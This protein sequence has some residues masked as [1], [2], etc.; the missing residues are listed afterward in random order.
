MKK[1]RILKRLHLF[2]DRLVF[3]FVFLLALIPVM[4]VAARK[5]F[6]T[7][8]PNST[9]YIHHLVLIVTF[10]GGM[11]TTREKKHLS[12]SLSFNL[13]K[14]AKSLLHLMI[15]V[16]ATCFT[17][18]FAWASLSFAIN[19]FTAEQKVGIISLKYIILLMAAGYSVMAL[20]FSL[21][22]ERKS[23]KIISAVTG[24]SL[25]TFL[26]LKPVLNSITGL[27]GDSPEIFRSLASGYES[28]ISSL[29][30]PLILLLILTAVFGMRIFIVLGGTA[31]LLFAK[32]GLPLEVVPN[33]AYTLLISHSIPAIP[34]FT[35]AGF[36]LSESK[37]GERIVGLFK[38]FFAWF[39]GGLAVVSVLACAFFTTF[40]GAS[41]VTVLALG[42]FL[43]IVLRR[44][45]YTKKFSTGLLTAS[46]SIGLLFPPSL[47][48]IIYGVTAQISIKDMFIGGLFPGA[49][50]ILAMAV[51]GIVYSVKKKIPRESFQ[52]KEALSSLKTSIWEILLPVIILVFYFG[53]IT[54]LVESGAVAVVYILIVELVITRDIKIKGLSNI[55]KKCI[56]IIGG[57]LTIIAIAKALSYFMVDAQIPVKLAEWAQSNIGSK[58]LFLL[59][60]N[61]CLLVTGFFM[62]IFS[63]ILVIVPLIIPLGQVFQIHPVHLGIIF[64]A[65]MELG[66]LTPPV[67]LNLFLASYR[68]EEPMQK[69]YRSILLFFFIQLISV[70]MIT[71]IPILST[72]HL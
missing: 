42:G 21:H 62:D 69:V 50:M 47:P 36:L 12:L 45:N 31:F 44:G 35:I 10:L 51:V 5:L 37:A 66:Y 67:G 41:G 7:G 23:L 53:G 4:E 60:L 16:L 56:P 18:A 11:V 32:S 28:V 33:E 49:L 71:Y 43:L 22:Q 48:I 52:F 58:Y 55:I 59:L 40:T 72:W 29:A 15:S 14:K 2:E 61:L 68:F 9:N 8:V 13:S 54:T 20:R 34:L 1:E 57:V 17:A 24:F 27:T 19:G 30:W 46:G 39:P 26:S 38:S 65:N 70:L 25:G 3:S 6:H 63:A 64:L